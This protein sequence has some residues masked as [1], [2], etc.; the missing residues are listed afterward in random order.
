MLDSTKPG[1]AN[2]R[3]F[4]LT[5]ATMVAV[6]F[7]LLLPWVF[8][9]NAQAWP[10]LASVV[11]IAWSLLA[12]AS[13]GPFYSR[14]MWLTEGVGRVVNGVVL[15]LVF[16]LLFL[17]L[18]LLMRVLGRDAMRRK[19]DESAKSYRVASLASTQRMDRPF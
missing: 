9:L 1:P 10:W 3:R 6:V 18:G 19:W 11:L 4:G 15:G 2:L 5:L 8:S 12:P 17:P 14:W 7:G 13:L 16:F